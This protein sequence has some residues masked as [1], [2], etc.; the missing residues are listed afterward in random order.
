MAVGC[1]M[2]LGEAGL[3]VPHDLMVAGF[4]DIPLARHITPSLQPM[5]VKIDRTR[6]TGMI[7]PLRLLRG[8]VPAAAGYPAPTLLLSSRCTTPRAVTRPDPRRDGQEC[9]PICKSWLS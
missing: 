6:S 9:L 3:K 1:L 2:R 7:M 4:D 5:Q 8:E